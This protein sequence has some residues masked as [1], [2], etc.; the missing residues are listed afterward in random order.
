MPTKFSCIH[1]GVCN[2]MCN[3]FGWVFGNE[4]I[5]HDKA[6]VMHYF[7]LGGNLASVVHAFHFI[8]IPFVRISMM[9]MAKKLRIS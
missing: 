9:K 5:G 2:Y 7:R 1:G 8:R 6:I 3:K 4:Q